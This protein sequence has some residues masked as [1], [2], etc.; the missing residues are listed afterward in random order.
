MVLA[1]TGVMTVNHWVVLQ[2]DDGSGRVRVG[3]VT[4]QPPGY[5]DHI[6]GLPGCICW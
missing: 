4:A 6:P 2:I 3:S 5:R 1:I